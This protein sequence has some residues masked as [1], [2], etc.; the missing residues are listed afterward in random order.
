LKGTC[1]QPA[2]QIP[3]TEN[4]IAIDSRSIQADEVQQ[5]QATASERSHHVVLYQTVEPR[6]Q[7]LMV[8]S[9][10]KRDEKTQGFDS[11]KPNKP[12]K[13]LDSRITASYWVDELQHLA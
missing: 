4:V 5:L 8:L 1:E 6:L 9:Q 10:R 2:I 11:I 13:S 7:T 12:D 3:S